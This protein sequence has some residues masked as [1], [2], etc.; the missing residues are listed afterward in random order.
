MAETRL[1]EQMLAGPRGRARL[2]IFPIA[3]RAGLQLGCGARDGD[4]WAVF[5]ALPPSPAV[6]ELRSSDGL[7]GGIGDY[8][9]LLPLFH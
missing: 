2:S 9:G 3:S 7:A 6:C 5:L 1:H 8:H 4:T